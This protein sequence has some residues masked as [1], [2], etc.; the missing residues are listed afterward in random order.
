MIVSLST[1]KNDEEVELEKEYSKLFPSF[2]EAFADLVPSDRLEDGNNTN[3][4][5]DW[6]KKKSKLSNTFSEQR[7]NQLKQ[8]AS[9][10]LDFLTTE[11]TD[12]FVAA[13][14]EDFL[15]RFTM[16]NQL[17]AALP[18]LASP[19]LEATLVP[20]FITISNLI[21]G[22][23]SGQY[24]SSKSSSITHSYNFYQ[25]PSLEEAQLVLPLLSVVDRAVVRLLD[26]FPENPVLEHIQLVRDRVLLLP[27]TSPLAKLL[28]G[29]E[30]LLAACQEW[31]KNAH[32]GVSLQ[33]VMDATSNLILRWRKL[34]LSNWRSL[35]LGGAGLAGLRRETGESYWLHVMAVVLE[36]KK[37]TETVQALV[38]FVEAASLA[39]FQTRLDI[40]ASVRQMLLLMSGG[41]PARRWVVACLAN[42]HAYYSRFRT[43]VDA[44]L[45]V[46]LK[47]AEKTVAEVV[48]MTRWKDTNF[49]S[50]KA[51]V[52]KT[53]KTMHKTLKQFT[54]AATL[55]CQGS[56]LDSGDPE[57]MS[58]GLMLADTHGP[59]LIAAAK[60]PKSPAVLSVV[61]NLRLE[62]LGSFARLSLKSFTMSQ[63]VKRRLTDLSLMDDLADLV[64][65]IVTEVET[66]AALR[67]DETKSKEQRKSQAGH[68]QQRKRRALNDLF[69]A[70]QGLGLSYRY[71]LVSCTGL[72]SYQELLTY[73]EPSRQ[74]TGW[75]HLEKY[76]FR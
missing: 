55:S 5:E 61:L 34:E 30:L 41:R 57:E 68:I 25:D 33:S 19:G 65:S 15:H 31:E 35:L 26:Q 52:D 36:A 59:Q 62:P 45:H 3:I 74:P 60:Q 75:T 63:T 32:R 37:K 46:H 66:M 4:E 39:D 76:F 40:L 9:F 23:H 28:T 24:G 44:A 27:V 29:L 56:L 53:R 54:K 1:P 2:R 71:G 8:L 73:L 12:G 49:W 21:I 14:Q 47:S 48:R 38:R 20:S 58:G 10:V 51:M 18:G 43:A 42:L 17:A 13:S 11:K 50:V 16:V 70:L 6:D 67:V 69:K 72:D 7:L 22:R 64:P